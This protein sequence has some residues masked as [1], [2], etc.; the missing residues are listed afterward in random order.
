MAT[1]G[2]GGQYKARHGESST[3]KRKPSAEY[4]IWTAMIQ[5]CE[6]E[7][8]VLYRNYGGRGIRVCERWRSSSA[9]FVDDVGRRP[10]PQH[11]LDRIHNDGH[12]EPGNVR[13][14][15]KRDQ[16]RKSRQSRSLTIWGETRPLIEWSD[17]YGVHPATVAGRIRR[18]WS[19]EDAVSKPAAKRS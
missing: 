5:R 19:L 14:C 18:G 3:R 1:V 6:Y 12:Y 13:R 2:E 9:A 17:K 11:T 7:K 15:S 16:R 4:V 8:H 10:S